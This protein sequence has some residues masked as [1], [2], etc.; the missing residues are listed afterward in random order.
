MVT[1][2]TS[3][4]H[5]HTVIRLITVECRACYQRVTEGAFSV[6]GPTELLLPLDLACGTLFRSSYAIQTSLTDY[7]DDSWRDTFF[8][9]HEHGAL[10]H[11][12]C[13]A[14][15]KDLLTL[16]TIWGPLT[17]VSPPPHPPPPGRGFRA[18]LHWLWSTDCIQWL[19]VR[20]ASAV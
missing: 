16:T 11:L 2:S 3:A 12:I 20:R 5:K 14:S 18:G 4:R 10:W 7:S 17:H 13:G 6:T 15:D 9:K 1:Q 19:S 8:G